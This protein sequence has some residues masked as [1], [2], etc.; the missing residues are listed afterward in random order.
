M[1]K[2]PQLDTISM[3]SCGP[4]PPAASWTF[5]VSFRLTTATLLPRASTQMGTLLDT[6]PIFLRVRATQSYGPRFP[7]LAPSRCW[8]LEVWRSCCGSEFDAAAKPH[9]K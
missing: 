3:L 7:S 9:A 6:Q 2:V 4:A 1:D 8:L 5:R